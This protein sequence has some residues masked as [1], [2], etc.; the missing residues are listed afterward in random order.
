MEKKEKT[1]SFGKEV[2]AS[3]KDF[4]KYQ[5]FAIQKTGNAIRYLLILMLLFVIVVVASYTYKIS[6]IVENAV[7]ALK[8]DM[9]EFYYQD[10]ELVVKSEE[11]IYIENTKLFSGMII[12]DTNTEEQEKI[13]GYVQKIKLYDN[14]FLILK[15]RIMVKTM[16]TSTIN[17]LLYEQIASNYNIGDFTKEEVITAIDGVNRVSLYFALFLTIFIYFFILYVL[18]TFIDVIMLAALGYVTARIVG[19]HIKYNSTFN[20][21]AHSVTLSILLNAIYIVANALTGFVIRYFDIM[22][23]TISF[24]YMVTAILIIRTNLIKRQIEI[25]KIQKEQEKIHEELQ[26]QKEEDKEEED[27]QEKEK[28]DTKEKKKKENGNIGDEAKGE[29]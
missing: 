9:P 8:N 11:P 6:Q 25:A 4:E 21:A 28:K 19:I 3:I 29:V 10:K 12:I 1:S 5:D 14:G 2:V 20:M 13:D 24:I 22:Y 7:V 16:A 26:R 27:G 23:T 17:T 18:S 15:D